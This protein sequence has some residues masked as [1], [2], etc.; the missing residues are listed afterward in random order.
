MRVSKKLFQNVS[1]LRDITGKLAAVSLDHDM[2]PEER[3]ETKEMV[4]E[5]KR[6]EESSSGKFIFRIRATPPPLGTGT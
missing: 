1:K 3:E 5:A 2:T 6:K 4:D